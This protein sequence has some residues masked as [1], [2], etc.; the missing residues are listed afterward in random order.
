MTLRYSLETILRSNE[1][2]R[3]SIASIKKVYEASEVV[4]LMK[5]GT[6]SYPQVEE[7]G[8]WNSDKGMSFGLK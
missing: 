3:K 5:E 7:K 6:I 2:F 8:E 4:N 1:E